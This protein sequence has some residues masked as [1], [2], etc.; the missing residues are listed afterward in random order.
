MR[1]N[2]CKWQLCHLSLNP[3]HKSIIIVQYSPVV[4][5]TTSYIIHHCHR[6]RSRHQHHE[7]SSISL[8][9]VQNHSQKG[10]DGY[11]A[12][13]GNE[14]MFQWTQSF[15]SKQVLVV[16]KNVVRSINSLSLSLS[17]SIVLERMCAAFVVAGGGSVM[18]DH[19]F[20]NKD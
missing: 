16:L 9:L 11:A 14:C 15:S 18:L 20:Q 5:T 7:V 19:T 3:Y 10:F 13:T 17:L 1:L 6:S 2:S 8:G 12:E 4:P